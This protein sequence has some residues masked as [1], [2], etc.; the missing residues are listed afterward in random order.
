MNNR[1]ERPRKTTSLRPSLAS[2][3]V[4]RR[5][6]R[7]QPAPASEA[8]RWARHNET[9]RVLAALFA[10]VAL[11]PVSSGRHAIRRQRN[12]H[13]GGRMKSEEQLA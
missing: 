6:V 3:C 2:V 12:R 9:D 8:I 11:T 10:G 7:P 13:S 1:S 4:A 5:A